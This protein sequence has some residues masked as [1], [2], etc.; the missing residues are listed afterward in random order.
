MNQNKSGLY[1]D[2]DFLLDSIQSLISGKRLFTGNQP[3]D[4]ALGGILATGNKVLILGLGFGT[5]LRPLIASIPDIELTALDNDPNVINSCSSLLKHLFPT[6]PPVNYVIGD[7]REFNNYVSTSFDVI[8]VDL[9]A[10]TVCP[11]FVLQK[12]FWE[13]IQSSLSPN[14]ITIVNTWGLPSHLNP[15]DANT[16]QSHVIQRMVETFE[17]VYTLPYRRNITLIGCQK[18]P[19]PKKLTIDYELRELDSI[20]FDL[21]PKRWSLA[22]KLETSMQ[23]LD[24]YNIKTTRTEID[25][26]MNR[27]TKKW[28]ISINEVLSESGYPEVNSNNLKNLTFDK[29]RASVLTYWLLDKGSY[30]ASFIPNFVGAY[31][32]THPGGLEWYP[33]WLDETCDELIKKDEF[34]FVNIAFWQLL[35]ITTNPFAHLDHLT[36]DVNKIIEKLKLSK[37]I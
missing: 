23:S 35:S 33:E 29:E 4:F 31:A 37:V 22:Q 11:E 5:S 14:G 13:L 21:L 9:F 10:E 6:L 8:C 17:N 32:F 24:I 7:A 19:K 34:W 12:P 3:D 28:M 27:R 15:F 25:I 26:E 30:E 16:Q 20:F 1:S 36:N 2:N 18:I